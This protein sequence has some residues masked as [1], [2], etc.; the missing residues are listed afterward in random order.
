[1]K[2]RLISAPFRLKMMLTLRANTRDLLRAAAS[3]YSNIY[4]KITA[5][6]FQKKKKNAFKR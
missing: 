3:H 1:M 5:H 6:P 4:F 2:N